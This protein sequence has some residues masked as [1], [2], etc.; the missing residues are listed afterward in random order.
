VDEARFGQDSLRDRLKI[1]LASLERA[2][3]KPHTEGTERIRAERQKQLAKW[4]AE[5][6][7]QHENGA[8]A[9]VAAALAVGA[10]EGSANSLRITVRCLP[11]GSNH[12][13]DTYEA[14]N[15]AAWG[16]LQRPRIDQLVAAGALIAA[17]IDRITSDKVRMMD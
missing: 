13:L 14:V 11:D 9:L 2:S 4:D 6:D 12:E 5:H 15:C 17:E 16:L 7:A 10:T 3:A 1:A 8:L